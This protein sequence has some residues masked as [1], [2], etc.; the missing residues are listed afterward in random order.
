MEDA[1]PS[2]SLPS[3]AQPFPAPLRIGGYVRWTWRLF[4]ST[5]VRL[6]FVFVGGVALLRL[7]QFLVGVAVGGVA[8]DDDSVGAAAFLLAATVVIAPVVGSI[9]V[10]IATPVFAGELGGLR[11]GSSTGWRNVRARLGA[12]AVGGLYVA[13]PV[14]A[15]LLFFGGIVRI[16]VLPAVLGPPIL[17]HA[18]AWERKDFRDAMTRT[19]NLLSGQWGRVLSALL[20]LALGA[21]LLQLVVRGVAALP[22]AGADFDRAEVFLPALLVEVVTSGVVWLFTAAAATVAYFDLRARFEE[23]DRAGLATEAQALS[24]AS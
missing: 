7:L 21:A 15:L 19:M 24:P 22:Q 12:V 11:V 2:T 9:L 1:E 5:F 6:V 16:V 18:I 13:I 23:L 14:L 8:A 20:L 3:S 10:A 4:R 17:V